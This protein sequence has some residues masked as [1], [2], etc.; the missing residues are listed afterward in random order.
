M[1]PLEAEGATTADARHA[2]YAQVVSMRM[3]PELARADRQ[4]QVVRGGTESQEAAQAVTRSH[5]GLTADRSEAK[6]AE[7]QRAW[8]IGAADGIGRDL[9]ADLAPGRL[10]VTLCRGVVVEANLEG[11]GSP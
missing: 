5:L 2:A 8:R 1:H 9:T 6:A 3:Q 10:T 11:V 7:E 4:G